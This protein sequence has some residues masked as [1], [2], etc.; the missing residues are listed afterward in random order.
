MVNIFSQYFGDVNPLTSSFHHF[1]REA[2]S[3]FI[4]ATLK[5]TCL[6]SQVAVKIFFLS[7]V[8]SSLTMLCVHFPCIDRVLRFMTSSHL[9]LDVGQ[10]WKLISHY[11]FKYYFAPL[12]CLLPFWESNYSSDLLLPMFCVF[13]PFFLSEL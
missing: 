1:C 3:Q 10:C 9:W 8:F 11:V 5:V 4:I 7:L 6:S 12:F 13:H 2:D